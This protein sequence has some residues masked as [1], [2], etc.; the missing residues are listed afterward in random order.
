MDWYLPCAPEVYS[1]N[2]LDVA[3][4]ETV[5]EQIQSMLSQLQS[6]AAKFGVTQEG[7]WVE[8]DSTVESIDVGIYQLGEA[9]RR[10]M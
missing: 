1:N 3:Q 8:T 5:L 10:L 6:D 7:I 9:A 4:F 2:T